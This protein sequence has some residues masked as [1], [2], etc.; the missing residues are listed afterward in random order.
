MKEGRKEV[1][2]YGALFTCMASRSIHIEVAHSLD[3]D[4]FLQA[5]QRFISRRGPIRELRSD[6][7]TNFVGA[8]NE[9]KKA[10]QEMDDDQIKAELLK[11]DIDWVRNPA[12][13]SNFGGVWERQIRSAR[14]VM[15]ALM[16]EH[17]HSLDDEVLRT[18]MCEAEAVVDNRPLTVDTLS[19]PLSPLPLTPSTLLTGKTK[20]VLPP[21]G[22]FQREDV[23][24]KQRWRCVQHIA[25]EFWS[26]WSKE[27]LQNLQMRNKWTRQCRNF[28]EGD[29][30]LLKDSNTC[31]N[32]WSLAKVLTTC[33]DD[34][35]QVRLVTVRTSKGSL[36]DRPINKLVLLL[37]STTERPRIPDEE[38]R[39]EKCD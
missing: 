12:T 31:R 29:V 35:G 38:P 13:A 27:Y 4:S 20:L 9:L 23:Y 2:R 1:K 17:G 7:G 16:R 19:D 21:P 33:P 15:A 8:Q 22:K 30:V 6:Q 26:R 5:L 14:N 18:L 39:S 28:T 32:Q 10:L 25:Y 3:T 36:L 37:E 24:C 34:Q 11:H